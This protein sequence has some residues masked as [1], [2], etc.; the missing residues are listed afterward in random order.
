MRPIP[1]TLAEARSD[2]P[3]LAPTSGV[4]ESRVQLSATLSRYLRTSPPSGSD[5]VPAIPADLSFLELAPDRIAFPLYSGIS[6]IAIDVVRYS[7]FIQPVA[8]A[9]WRSEDYADD[10]PCRRTP[11]M[12]LGGYLGGSSASGAGSG[13]SSVSVGAGSGSRL[14]AAFGAG[15]G[16]ES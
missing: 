5:P 13:L 3:V 6:R 11:A 1:T 16:F 7:P 9:R 15:T 8:D 2:S 4:R 14:V 12:C 10:R